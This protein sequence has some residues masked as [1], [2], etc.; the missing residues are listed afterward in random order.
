MNNQSGQ[1]GRRGRD[2]DALWSVAGG[3]I[4]F[5]AIFLTKGLVPMNNQVGSADRT[6]STSG[7]AAIGRGP[8][9]PV[10]AVATPT[11]STTTI[12]ATEEEEEEEEDEEWAA[13]EVMMPPNEG[14]ASARQ[15]KGRPLSTPNVVARRP[16]SG[17]R[18]T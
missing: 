2:D 6:R 17:P 10:A 14:P 13:E 12:T 9:P 11:A 8:E 7:P 16:S 1:A 15:K 4:F 3:W 5:T 18:T